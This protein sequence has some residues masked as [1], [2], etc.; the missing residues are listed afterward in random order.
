MTS[1]LLEMQFD[2]VPRSYSKNKN[3]SEN[4]PCSF[5]TVQQWEMTNDGFIRLKY[6]PRLV[7]GVSLPPYKLGSEGTISLEESFLTVQSLR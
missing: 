2:T 5:A 3:E 6:N 4:N 7:L 1:S